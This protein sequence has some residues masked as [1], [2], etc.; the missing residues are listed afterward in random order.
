MAELQVGLQLKS[1]REKQG[2]P[3]SGGGSGAQCLLS[4]TVPSWVDPD[5]FVSFSA[6]GLRPDTDYKPSLKLDGNATRTSAVK[7][8][9]SLTGTLSF[10]LSKSKDPGEHTQEVSVGGASCSLTYTV[11]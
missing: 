10:I 1:N 11:S 8:H 9:T 7:W 4:E 5:G 6:W 2:M 3:S